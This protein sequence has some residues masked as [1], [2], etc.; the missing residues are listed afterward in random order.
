MSVED[1][2]RKKL[3]T[4]AMRLFSQHGIFGVSIR[5]IAAEAGAKNSAAVHYYFRTK[6]D[7]IQELVVD[8][9]RRSDRARNVELDLLERSGKSICVEDI[10]R[11]IVNVETLGTGDS[12]Q[13]VSPPIG[14]GHMRFVSAMQL[15]HR[16]RFMEAIG[17]RWNSSY[18]RCIRHIRLALPAIPKVILNQRLIFMYL[19]LNA[20]LAAREGAFERHPDGGALWGHPEALENLINV[21][22]SGMVS[23]CAGDNP[24]DPLSAASTE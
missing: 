17:N 19:F 24:S 2:T 12:E 6:D 22:T 3:K 11:L 10:I 18:V 14:F 8:A 7:L 4:A 16:E 13:I 23:A 15:N 5:D 1:G 21:L 20:S 9:A